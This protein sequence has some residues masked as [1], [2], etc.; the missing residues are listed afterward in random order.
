MLTISEEIKTLLRGNYRQ[1]VRITFP[2]ND[3]TIEITETDVIQGS[4][5]W[6]RYAATG[7][8]LELGTATA[9]EIEFTIRNTGYLRDTAG[10]Q[11]DIK[12][13]RF[14][15]K[16]MAVEVGIRKWGAR[17]WEDA[18]TLW[19]PIGRFTVMN[20]PHKFATIH[21]TALDRMTWF[22][23]Y[24][25]SEDN[26]FGA[27][28]TI[29][30][31]VRKMCEALHIEY[32]LPS[33]LPNLDLLVD[34]VKLIE[35]EPQATYRML[36]QW[37][38]QLTGTMAYINTEGVLVF[39]WL[40]RAEGVR[41]TPSTRYSSTVYEPVMFGGLT[42]EKNEQFAEFGSDSYYR[43][44]IT[45]NALIQGDD[46]VNSYSQ[47]LSDLWD[48]LI[49]SSIPYR[50]FEA[51]TVPMPYLEPLDIV[52]YE[53]NNG[54]VFDT[55]ITHVT[56]T[57]NGST[58]VMAAGQSETEAKCVTPSGT[59]NR[60]DADIKA[61]KNRIA[62]LENATI[63]ARNR[64][65]DMVRLALGLHRI[66]VNAP[67]GGVLY[68]FTTANVPDKSDEYTPTL[69]D[70]RGNL[71]DNDVIYL[72]SGAG[73]FWCHGSD[74]DV[75]AQAPKADKGWKYGIAKDGSAVLGLVNTTGIHVS[76][77]GTVYRTEI[78][79]EDFSVYQGNN[80]VF[81]LN[82][83]LESQINRL[84]VKANIEQP[85]VDNNAYIR[86]GSAML[87]PAAGGLDIV[88]AEDIE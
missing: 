60:E 49:D 16:E 43:Y 57:L 8:M 51:S 62:V 30:S 24:I 13:V 3:K 69:A 15:G 46:W 75:D 40:E 44:S 5:T 27:T 65:T 18:Q 19:F 67:D 74:W 22:D 26:P 71:S 1:L 48:S 21:I 35:E 31:M 79:P 50:P 17:R 86:I 72:M 58:T 53:D 10:G 83:Q 2:H 81:R 38:A 9:S 59:T 32:V 61:L 36:V 45:N 73:L 78:N 34:I 55:L 64:I 56:F 20:M 4:F 28:E 66:E 82:G 87:V 70:L 42:V 77:E 76:D 25:P 54:D 84:L 68:Y 33:T 12:E 11:V 88:Y 37:S 29:A 63:A 6:D 52:E 23:M 14:E 41:L 47:P 39:R 7:D 85:N 80:L